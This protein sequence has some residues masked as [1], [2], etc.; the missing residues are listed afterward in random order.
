MRTRSSRGTDLPRTKPRHKSGTAWVSSGLPTRTCVQ[1]R[2]PC[3][4]SAGPLPGLP[5]E[6]QVNHDTDQQDDADG[7][8]HPRGSRAPPTATTGATFRSLA[9]LSN[10]RNSTAIP[11]RMVPV[12]NRSWPSGRRRLWNSYVSPYATA[13]KRRRGH[14]TERL[15]ALPTRRTSPGEIDKPDRS[16]S[17][18]SAARRSLYECR[19]TASVLR[20]TSPSAGRTLR[21][22]KETGR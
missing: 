20:R 9:M 22:I 21:R 16:A 12:Q 17:C 10:K 4:R 1:W 8:K 3:N 6:D 15:Q 19:H 13:G 11:L 2:R 7:L 18:R 5:F 14:A